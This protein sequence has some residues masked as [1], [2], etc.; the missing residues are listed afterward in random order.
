MD[1]QPRSG[2]EHY[3]AGPDPESLRGEL[4]GRPGRRRVVVTGL[5]VISPIG[6]G[7]DAFWRSL[8]EG[9]S[10]I[11]TIDRF[12]T[13][14]LPSKVAGLV[15]GFEAEAYVGRK[16]ARR[17]DRA[18]QM[19]VAVA[20][21]AIEAAGLPIRQHP[22]EV[23]VAYGAGLSMPLTFEGEFEVFRREGARRVSPFLIPMVIP[24]AVAGTIS[25]HTG[26]QGPTVP[27]STA[28]ATGNDCI[29]NAYA[30]IQRGV[31]RA[32]IAGGVDAPI[33]PFIIA[34]FANAKA[35]S[36][37]NEPP[38][39]ASCP[40]DRRR[41]GFVIAEGAGAVVIEDEAWARARGAPILAEVLGYAATSDAYHATAPE[42][43]GA[44][45]ARAI[46]LALRDA[47]LAPT[48]IDYVSAHGTST[49]LNDV[50]ET[51]AIKRALG[52]HAY[53]TPISSIKSMTGHLLGG[54]GAVEFVAAVLTIRHGFIPPTINLREPD[55]ECDLDYVP[56]VGRPAPVRVVLSNSL[57][58]GG[59]NSAI[60]VGACGR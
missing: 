24:N 25:I 2:T 17:M 42:E 15:D 46:T 33:T 1:H 7:T 54:A 8:R 5:G 52:E 35:L 31:V 53:R 27:I 41:D 59:Q 57:G 21:M 13:S 20:S 55:P 9:R 36:R 48:A 38:E 11:R 43:S 47:G 22:E 51:R 12:D 37:R 60:L 58:F 19:G 56:L 6:V 23:G 26:A 50:V 40:F 14:D 10:G 49:P 28:C 34:G 39:E 16:A 30:L 18:T 4:E 3:H 29:G 45:A 32:A 44:G